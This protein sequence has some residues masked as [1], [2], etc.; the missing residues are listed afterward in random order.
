MQKINICFLVRFL[1][2]VLVSG[3]AIGAEL[4]LA[5]L[6]AEGRAA[7]KLALQLHDEGEYKAAELHFQEAKKNFTQI[8]K[9][10]D[11]VEVGPDFIWITY[12]NL[13]SVKFY[14]EDI[15]G[16]LSDYN[17]AI[18]KLT[19][20]MKRHAVI[21]GSRGDIYY[22]IQD[23]QASIAD[24]KTAI[25]LQ[26]G[27]RNYHF[28]LARAYYAI[29]QVMPAYR[30]Y[31]KINVL[32]EP[33]SYQLAANILYDVAAIQQQSMDIGFSLERFQNREK[34]MELINLAIAEDPDLKDVY[35]DR[36]RIKELAGDLD[37]DTRMEDYDEAIRRNNKNAEIFYGRAYL[38]ASQEDYKGA[39]QDQKEAVKLEPN[40]L[41]YRFRLAFYAV[42]AE[43]PKIAIPI[44]T[45]LIDELPDS[46]IV[47]HYRGLA[48]EAMGDPKAKADFIK[49][50]EL[51]EV[52]A[53]EKLAELNN[54]N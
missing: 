26:K 53:Q 23:Y 25:Q 8:S 32:S 45:Q 4:S 29:D 27:V 18:A 1:V 38:K 11:E 43:K 46:G 44:L 14:L 37:E 49:A 48:R 40:H 17:Q 3:Q 36:A 21:F 6:A 20:P 47:Y 12:Y 7:Q 50:A 34:A 2:S 41:N 15:E 22:Q 28:G 39:L 54:Q 30:E 33:E 5:Q 52:D 13:G 51:G 35:F 42:D 24:F 9:R 31:L 16:A 10:F 19:K